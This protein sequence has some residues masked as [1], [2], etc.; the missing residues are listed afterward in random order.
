MSRFSVS[1]RLLLVW[2]LCVIAG[3]LTPF[4]FS[5]PPGAHGHGLRAF[6][7]GSYRQY[8]ADLLI[9]L[10]LFVPLGVLLHHEGRHR[11]LKLLSILIL[12]GTIGVLISTAV[13]YL[14]AFLPTRDSSF[15]DVLA[16]TGGALLGV[17]AD[18][19]W[20]ARAEAHVN[21]LRAGT[22]S[23]MLAGLMAAFLVVALVIS[24]ALQARTRL[25]NWSV[26]YP[27][28]IG[29][30]GSGDRPWRGR[31]FALA[32]SDAAT[33][34]ASARRFSSG[35]PIVVSGTE[36][37]AFDFNGEPPYRD[38][39]G[40]LPDLEWTQR[41]NTSHDA[42]I[43]L[44]G[45]SWLR[46]DGPASGLVRRLRE[47]NAFTLRVKCATDDTGQYGPARIISNSVSRSLRNFTLGQQGTDL[48][49]S[50]RTPG[51]GTNGAPLEVFVP[52]VFSD[53]R[54]REIL[55]TYDGASLL[56]AMAH[57]DRMSLT[58][59]TPGASVALAIPSLNVQ[60]DELQIYKLAYVAA[61]CLV[62]GVLVGL[63][64][65]T[66]ADRRVFVVSWILAFAV[67]FEATLVR[68]SG[69]AFDWG[70]VAVTAGVGTVV[71]TVFGVA[72]SPA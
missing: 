67:L 16:N 14:Q 62:P 72:L 61:L 15:R 10:L 26:E 19:V 7:Y 44:A 43:R 64:G 63:L 65:H 54:P 17:A 24:A 21:R 38:A 18:R 37:A 22:S 68:A 69:R 70:N 51:T 32:M 9:N 48:V 23:A 35:E 30:E 46:S 45:R 5:A 29:N 57:A 11:S 36:I 34:L 27:L 20:G 1:T 8:P 33:P 49:F 56:T 12:A 41:P 13:E 50:L 31:V 53:G 52:G 47:T 42:G 25:S 6:Q 3:T 2:L 4:N 59:L 58:E 39:A 55:V 40:N 60:P 66:R 28:L 71:L